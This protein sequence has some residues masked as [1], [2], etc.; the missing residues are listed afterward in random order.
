MTCIIYR[1][2]KGTIEHGIECESTTC[3]IEHLEGL[4]AAGWSQNPPGYEPPEPIMAEEAED[5]EDSYADLEEQ[6]ASL[7]AQLEIMKEID[8][9]SQAEIARLTALLDEGDEGDSTNLNPVRIAAKEAGVE[10]WET[11]RIAT[12]QAALDSLKDEQEE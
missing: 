4:L 1:E 5:E 11:K 8:E 7:T 12:L 9:K 3:E 6:V 10:G 2:G